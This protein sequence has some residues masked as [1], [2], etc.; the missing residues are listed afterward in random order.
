MTRKPRTRSRSVEETAQCLDIP[1]ATVRTR[2]FRARAQLRE[3]IER[4]FDLGLRD[5]FAFAGE[6][7]DR[8]VAGVLARLDDDPA[9]DA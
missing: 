3:A 6:R 1:A 7:C 4:E 5:A 8:I 2:Y 9:H